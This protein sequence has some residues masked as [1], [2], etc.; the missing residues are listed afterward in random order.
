MIHIDQKIT[1]WER[2]SL[3]DECKQD[4]LQFLKNN[5][6][7]N[8]LDIYDWAHEQGYDPSSELLEGTQ[9]VMS[10]EENDNQPTMEITY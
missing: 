6:F 9:E 3:N 7:A 8:S 10:P 4:L 2:L 1:A 5:P